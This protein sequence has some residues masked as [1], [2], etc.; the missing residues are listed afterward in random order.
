MV[1]LCLL[2]DLLCLIQAQVE[3][4]GDAERAAHELAD[5]LLISLPE[6]D[7]D[8]DVESHAH[9]LC[10]DSRHEGGQGRGHLIKTGRNAQAQNDHSG[11]VGGDEDLGYGP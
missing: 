4:N 8:R 10:T 6:S 2:D 9:L 11:L 3:G 5:P 7:R 1:R